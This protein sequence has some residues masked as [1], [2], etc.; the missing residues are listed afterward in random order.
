[1]AA[2]EGVDVGEGGVGVGGV[3]GPGDPGETM[4]NTDASARVLSTAQGNS[5]RRWPPVAPLP[6][7]PGARRRRGALVEGSVVRYAPFVAQP[8]DSTHDPKTSVIIE[9][10]ATHRGNPRLYELV[11]HSPKTGKS[12]TVWAWPALMDYLKIAGQPVQ[13][14]WP[15]HQEPRPDPEEDTLPV[16][17]ADPQGASR[18]RPPRTRSRNQP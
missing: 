16:A 14:P 5:C 1:M 9:S 11:E 2:D 7:A 6:P 15:P 17:V 4:A 10:D 12:P 3:Q 8:G 13:G 18:N